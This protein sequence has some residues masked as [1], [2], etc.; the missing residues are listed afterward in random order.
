MLAP[1]PWNW[2]SQ[3]EGPTYSAVTGIVANCPG[4]VWTSLWTD[5]PSERTCSTAARGGR[6][7]AVSV[8]CSKLW[9]SRVF[10]YCWT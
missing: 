4:R 3:T 10:S 2:P 1:P 5:A 9:S 7:K 6:S 8:S